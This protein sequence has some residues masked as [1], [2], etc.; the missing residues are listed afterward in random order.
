MRHNKGKECAWAPGT[1][2]ADV[3]Y[4]GEHTRATIA[5]MRG[6]DN[7][8]ASGSAW[9]GNITLALV[10]GAVAVTLVWWLLN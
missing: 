8:G 7:Q 2:E 1:L 6:G 5:S 10:L 9:L 4:A 3:T